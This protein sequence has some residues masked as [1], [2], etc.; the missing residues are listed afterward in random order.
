MNKKGQSDLSGW[1]NLKKLL[2]QLDKTQI[3][4][5][6]FPES[7]YGADNDNLQVAQVAAWQEFGTPFEV[8]SHI[9]PRP[10]MRV[11]FKYK[12]K[13]PDMRK[14]IVSATNNILQGQA[15]KQSLTPLAKQCQ[16]VMVEAIDERD[17]PENADSTKRL[18]GFNDPLNEYGDMMDA[19]KA[20]ITRG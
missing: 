20:K 8:G 2:N 10:F 17:D 4:T 11:D 7:R 12:M 16:D 5:G 18:K 6:F 1:K 15:V 19:V 3:E 9:P 13:S 14:H